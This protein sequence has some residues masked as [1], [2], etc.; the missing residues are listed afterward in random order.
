MPSSVRTRREGGDLVL[1]QNTGSSL[2]ESEMQLLRFSKFAL[3]RCFVRRAQFEQTIGT[4][5]HSL[6]V[7][8]PPFD[9]FRRTLG[10]S[11]SWASWRCRGFH[12]LHHLDR[13]VPL[14]RGQRLWCRRQLG[15]PLC[16]RLD[17]PD[18]ELWRDGDR[19]L[20]STLNTVLFER[21]QVG[22][23]SLLCKPWIILIAQP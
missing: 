11:R 17:G 2:G 21:G 13:L 8:A 12:H 7:P 18:G 6:E 19:S 1:S 5:F 15:R 3:I 16:G 20:I 23:G 9:L 10:L 4:V 14:L 22:N